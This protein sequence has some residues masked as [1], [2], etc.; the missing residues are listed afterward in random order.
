M[1]NRTIKFTVISVML[2]L[3][4]IGCASTMPVA[5]DSWR[6][7]FKQGRSKEEITNEFN[8]YRGK[9]WNYYTR[10]R[11][12]AEGGFHEEA[13]A[14]YKKAIEIRSK[15]S[16]AARSY[17]LHFWDYFARRELGIAYYELK[18]YEQAKLELEASLATADSAKAKFYL[19]KCNEEILKTTKADIQPPQIKV[20]SHTDG[21]IVNTPI[22]NLSGI[23]MDD[24]FVRDVTIQGK[25]QF[26]ELAEK[27]LDFSEKVALSMGEN[28]LH[29]ASTDLMGKASQLKFRLTL[30]LRPPILYLD[31]IEV[32]RKNGRNVAIVKGTVV[33]DHGI[34]SL[35]INNTVVQHGDE[36]EVHFQQEIVLA[37]GNKVSFRVTDVAGNE[38]SGEQK[39]TVK[40]SLWP[41]DKWNEIKFTQN[42]T[43]NKPVLLAAT[44]LSGSLINTFLASQTAVAPDAKNNTSAQIKGEDISSPIIRSSI[45][46]CIVYDENF[47]FS[48]EA[49]DDSGIEKL[50]I[51]GEAIEIRPGKHVFFNHFLK[52]NEGENTVTVMAID[53]EGN[54]ASLSP[55]VIEKKTFELFDTEA[56]FTISLLPLRTYAEAS[57]YSVALLPLQSSAHKGVPV[58]R[59]YAKLLNAFDDDPKRFN[60]VE[61]EQSKLLEI[62][63]EQKI[64]NS[65]LASPNTAI[66]IGKIQ[67]AEGMLFG[68]VEE[69]D[70][71]INVTLRLVD[72]ETTQILANT[73]VYDEDK[74]DKNIDWLMYGLALKMKQQFPMAHGEVIHVS[75][76][77]FHINVGA[78][79]GL[80]VGMKLLV[81]REIN[82]GNFRIKE[83]LEVIARVVQVQPDTSF[84]KITTA[85]DS[86]DIMKDDMVI[87][88]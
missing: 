22:V 12:Y 81:F 30:D 24:Q 17:G 64:S 38:T 31:D 10:G 75:G 18:Q 23:A 68:S 70:K 8:L 87:T 9:W 14:D 44:R 76:K 11:W 43:I 54:E 26:I 7:Y 25:R 47:F 72:T 21:E 41:E 40:A 80:S 46:S 84:V 74:N 53:A 61:R 36:K 42:T 56:R 49:H 69:G 29:M 48:G 82:V 2:M 73:D 19:N 63:K 59:L 45:K 77:G 50:F 86:V 15:D 20:T 85:K 67:A 32:Q 27:N 58:E 66:K 83:P 65:E 60:F 6:E 35:S 88:K 13:I 39:L 33:D 55:V 71:G 79:H 28:T 52:L 1:K 5:T 51:N 16:R 62:L 3:L 78:N 57:R 34:K 37:E 4:S